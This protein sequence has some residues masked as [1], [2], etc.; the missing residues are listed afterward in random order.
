MKLR[1]LIL[2]SYG[3]GAILVTLILG[4]SAYKMIFKT[5]LVIFTIAITLGA[6][7]LAFTIN[8]IL[9]LP[10]FKAIDKLSKESRKI[11]QG[12]F[13]GKVEVSGS[14]ETRMLAEDFNE[15]SVKLD[16]MFR[17]IKE[18]ERERNELIANLSHDIK[19]P[20]A[21]IRSFSEALL[22]GVLVEEAEK[23]Q[24]L[25]TIQRETVRL[26][27]LV[28]ELMEL[29]A[30]EKVESASQIVRI[31]ID[32]LVLDVLQMFDVQ[33]KR[34][35]RELCIHIAPDCKFIYANPNFMVRILCNLIQNA[36]KFSEVGTNIE[37]L[38]KREKETMFFSVKD[39][40]IGISLEEQ[41]RIFERLYRVEKSRNLAHGG[42]GLGL[43]IASNLAELSG[44]ELSVMS[45]PNEGSTFILKLPIKAF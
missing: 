10:A 6:S 28:N 9:L 14:L 40:G 24:Y 8:Y 41:K 21:S 42:S 32:Q 2:L 30:I 4:F 11:A 20:I 3:I 39:Y 44:G 33:L 15:M 26:A 16:E 27:D 7:I 19:T 12:K 23:E 1:T 29:S 37:I 31:W 45:V 13:S 38:V 34:E 5:N 17:K 43:H 18:G 22:D 25:R 36:L 35:G